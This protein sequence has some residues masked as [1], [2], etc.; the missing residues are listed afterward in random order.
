ML[1]NQHLRYGGAVGVAFCLLALPAAAQTSLGG[2]PEG[3]LRPLAT[4][5]PVIAAPTPDVAAY[6]AADE[7][8]NHRPLRYGALID[9]GVDI[10][11]GAWT[12]LRDGSRVWRLQLV[13]PGAMSLAVEFEQFDLPVGA[14]MYVYDEEQELVLG[15]YTSENRHEDGGFVFEPFPGDRLTLELEVPAGASEPVLLTKA[16]IHDYR[17]IFGM[18]NGTVTVGGGSGQQSLGAC[19]IDVNCPEGANWNDQKRATMRTL[20]NGALCSGALVNN[21]ALD[22]TRYVMT[23]DHCGQTANTVFTFLYQRPNCSSGAAPTNM[24]VTGCTVLTTSPAYDSRLLRINSA[25]PVGYQPF[26][27]GWTRS[28]TGASMAFA[29]GH[30]S[31]GP[32]MISIDNNGTITDPQYWRV[33]WNTGTLEG[34]SSGGPLF[35]QNGR[36]KGAACCVNDFVCNNQTAYFGRF[37]LFYNSNAVAQWLDP[38][39]Q[40]PTTLNGID[41]QSC[42]PAFQT[43]FTSPNS[44]GPGAIIGYYGS[45]SVNT[46]DFNLLTSGLPPN[47][48]GLYYYGQNEI[49]TPFGNGYRCVGSPVTRLGVMQA[50]TFGDAVHDL[51]LT[52][53]QIDA[54]ETWIFQY[55]YRNPA[56][57]GAGFNLSDAIGVPFC[58]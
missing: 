32:K 47:G 9:V 40:N 25:I 50:N 35:D 12:T 55:W 36:F 54:G 38:L 42:T 15:A 3:L 43:C 27:A 57:G 26:F 29:M 2:Q 22:G 19:L 53:T 34:G 1:T 10:A 52:G 6:M 41:P 21:T 23:A 16:I 5:A 18:M 45:R 33:T 24:T 31:G 46:N 28:G 7:E 8:R 37:D 4:Q 20:S 51:N 56:G 44:V 39:G 13:S 58:P 14:K 17:D 48:F 30:P 11:D 49:L